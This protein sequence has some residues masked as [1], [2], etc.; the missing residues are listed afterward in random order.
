MP[1]VNCCKTAAGELKKLVDLIRGTAYLLYGGIGPAS[2][3]VKGMSQTRFYGRM[4]KPEDL[5][6]EELREIRK[7]LRL[8]RDQMLAYLREVI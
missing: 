3:H 2:D 8:D 6:I 1:K 7:G 5:T 4:K